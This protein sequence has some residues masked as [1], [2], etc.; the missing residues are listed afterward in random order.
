MCAPDRTLDRLGD[1]GLWARDPRNILCA[2]R[3]TEE[4]FVRA[5]T[6]RATARLRKLLAT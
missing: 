3:E 5:E 2:D 1:R 6:E 4:A